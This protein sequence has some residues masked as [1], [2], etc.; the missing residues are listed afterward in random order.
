MG[1]LNVTSGTPDD[2]ARQRLAAIVESS[3]DAIL[4]KDLKGIITS[5]N[6]AAERIFGYTAAE[7]IGRSV[8]IIVP[9]ERRNEEEIVQSRIRSGTF[10]E[11]F[12]TVRLRKDG[13]RIEV[14]ISVSPIKNAT[15]V[16][17]GTSKIARD[18]AERRRLDHIRDELLDRERA[19]RAEAVLA[20]DRLAFLA[21]VS[22]LLIS[23]LDYE[24][25]LDR[26]VHLAIPRLGDYCTV[27]VHDENAVLR[28]VASGHV[29]RAKEPVVREMVR[30]LLEERGDLPTFAAEV[31]KTGRLRLVP[32][33]SQSEEFQHV[34]AIRPDLVRESLIQPYSYVGVPLL[35]RGRT[36]GVIAFGTT[37][38]LSQREY[39]EADVP[40]IEE[41]ARRV[42]LAVENARLFQ[43]AAELNRLKDEFLAT[44]S[45]ELRTPLNAIVGWSRMLGTG[46]LK[47]DNF[48]RAVE[49]IQ[50]NAQAQA[51]IVDDILEVARGVAGNVRLEIVPL[52]LV[53]VAQ[54]GVDGIAPTAAVKQIVID[55]SAHEPVPI[56]GDPLR[57]Q[58]V[59]GNILSNAVKFT[60]RGG[61]VRVDARAVH[62]DAEL[63][64]TDTGIGISPAFLPHVFDK[65]RQ[66]DAS[67][68]RTYGGLGIG[69]AIAR[70][71]IELHGGTVE[72][73]SDGEGK[74]AMFIVR[75][76][77][78][79]RPKV[80]LAR[81]T[82]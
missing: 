49:A 63:R 52:D 62:G 33:V 11:P 21:D 71:L 44:L 64:V 50:R 36:V 26:A 40:L 55:V 22:A 57:L 9:P 69:L 20:R 4:S 82:S 61:A 27:L 14:S 74:G 37:A 35:L 79:H 48:D 23:S 18:I 56:S 6:R 66:A 31:A 38:D 30:M 19:A 67:F 34:E 78:D 24:E 60:P 2:L 47:D 32:R 42:A 51:Q 17:V 41:F 73:H 13:T 76:P 81:P 1:P 43:Q 28:H 59:L 5:W 70:H 53:E 80:D 25:T 10:V 7:A 45:H 54:R 16:I 15:G 65:F 75:L 72:A 12:E 8:A 39:S 77:L 3:E 58:Q 68:T 29:D 46:K